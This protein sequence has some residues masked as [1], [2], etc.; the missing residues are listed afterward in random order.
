M[1]QDKNM[2]IGIYLGYAPLLNQS[3]VGEGLGRYLTVLIK[4][5]Q[6]RGNRVVL[7]CPVWLLPQLRELFENYGFSQDSIEYVSTS[8]KPALLRVLEMLSGPPSDKPKVRLSDKLHAAALSLVDN[9]MGFLAH[10]KNGL[11]L[12]FLFLLTFLVLF[13]LLPVFLLY[14]IFRTV[15]YFWRRRKQAKS[16]P[17]PTDKKK[18]KKADEEE[19]EE[20]FFKKVKGRL[21][22]MVYG[23]LF[24]GKVFDRMRTDA[25][26]ELL[27]RISRMKEKPDVWF[28]LTSFWKE[29]FDIEGVTVACFPD[30]SPWIFAE[31]TSRYGASAVTHQV[32]E[33]VE[34]GNY[35]VTYCDYQKVAMLS[36]VLGKPLENIKTIPLFVNET[37]PA[38]DIR[39]SEDQQAGPEARE[40]FARRLLDTL[41][42]RA[43][44]PAMRAYWQGP[45]QG[46]DF[47]G[48]RYLFY[49]SQ[50]RAN[51]NVLSLVRA[52]H[53]LRSQEKIEQKLVLTGDPRAMGEVYEYIQENGLS[54]DVI[55]FPGVSN[56]Q[57]SA[58]YAC[59]DLVVNPTMYEGGFLM[60]FSE[61][62]SVGTPSVMS[63][64]PQVTEVV[65]GYDID[66]C[67]FN[68]T[69][70]LDIADKILHG[71]A[72]RKD[73][74]R[75]QEKLYHTL[76]GWTLRDAGR[77]YEE[78]FQYF[79]E[80]DASDRAVRK[81]KGKRK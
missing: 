21:Y 70:P 67:L 46:Y 34:Q 15:S 75:R 40:R 36:N 11:V 31:G 43:K 63:R 18:G 9:W 73:L 24:G 51:K 17:E 77:E 72:N 65:A 64:I 76:S 58:L 20:S 6:D 61:G 49:S 26:K 56:Q 22:T 66:D 54:A 59:A 23:R 12:G 16:K 1:S 32:R 8:A 38:I 81:E 2:K 10:I 55:S 13:V 35:F 74:Q 3:L 48:L 44:S 25:C 62:M 45:L 14:G 33:T 47:S 7:A 52:Y 29:F 69:D 4:L 5:L 80:K 30:L 68:P 19:E 27:R 53:H 78:M 42:K 28:C 71:L 37:L 50:V 41:P 57:L 60:I 79:I 39:L